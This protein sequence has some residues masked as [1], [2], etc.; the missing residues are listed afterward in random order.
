MIKFNILDKIREAQQLAIKHDIK[1]NAIQ[2]SKDFVKVPKIVTR[3]KG[4][5]SVTNPMIC[6][7]RCHIDNDNEL[8]EEYAFALFD[9]GQSHLDVETVK[10]GEWIDLPDYGGGGWAMLGSDEYVQPRHCSI[11]GDV[12]TKKY[13]Y[14]PSCGAKMENS[15]K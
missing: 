6:G 1:V 8:P 2:I 10:H 9:D 12:Y 11:C 5:V 13:K 14:C 15:D 4:C 7:L 3:N